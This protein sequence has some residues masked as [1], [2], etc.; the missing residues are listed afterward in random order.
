[1]F[2]APSAGD[3]T[4]PAR[5]RPPFPAA[6]KPP[7]FMAATPRRLSRPFSARY[8]VRF[9][10]LQ[11]ACS[12]R[13]SISV[14]APRHNGPLAAIGF[15]RSLFLWRLAPFPWAALSVRRSPRPRSGSGCLLPVACCLMPVAGCRLPVACPSVPPAR[16]RRLTES[17]N[18]ENVNHIHSDGH[19]S[20]GPARSGAQREPRASPRF[21]RG[22]SLRRRQRPNPVVS[23]PAI[24]SGVED[25]PRCYLV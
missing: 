1:M 5:R 16:W 2:P 19:L 13:N 22:A 9:P 14:I 10:P 21:S 24:R 12:E 6:S 7:H 11:T 18:S 23:Q 3:C 4:L 25:T 8:W 20:H 15:V 17:R